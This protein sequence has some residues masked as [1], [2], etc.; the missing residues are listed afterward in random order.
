MWIQDVLY[1]QE[2]KSSVSPGCSIGLTSCNTRVGT[3]GAF[4]ED[5]NNSSNNIYLLSNDHVLHLKYG[6]EMKSGARQPAHSDYEGATKEKIK[7]EKNL[8]DKAQYINK[9]KEEIEYRSDNIKNWKNGWRSKLA[10]RQNSVYLSIT[11]KM[12]SCDHIILWK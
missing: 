12:W 1:C 9:N 7:G 4:V 8:L 11:W 2:Y 5:K 3:L 10:R 6:S